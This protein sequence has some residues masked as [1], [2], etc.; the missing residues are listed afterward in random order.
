MS[1]NRSSSTPQRRQRDPLKTH[2]RQTVLERTQRQRAE[3]VRRERQW[4][5]Q[6]KRGLLDPDGAEWLGAAHPGATVA[7]GA[8]QLAAV[9]AAGQWLAVHLPTLR[10][11]ELVAA[12]PRPGW[13][14]LEAIL[15]GSGPLAWQ[16]ALEQTD[17]WSVLLAT[18]VRTTA[19]L[20][21]SGRA[22]ESADLVLWRLVASG[23]S[24]EVPSAADGGAG[25]RRHCVSLLLLST[26]SL[27]PHLVRRL[28]RPPTEHTTAVDWQEV[29]ELALVV[30]YALADVH[31]W[32]VD[33]VTGQRHT[34]AG[35]SADPLLRWTA[36]LTAALLAWLWVA[37]GG[38][39]SSVAVSEGVP[40]GAASRL[41]V[42]LAQLATEVGESERP[43]MAALPLLNVVVPLWPRWPEEVGWV[44]AR[45]TD[46]AHPE[47][48]QQVTAAGCAPYVVAALAPDAP[49]GLVR[50][51]LQV[52]CNLSSGSV[53]AL[54]AVLRHTV[55]YSYLGR[56]LASEERDVVRDVLLLLGNTVMEGE[57]HRRLIETGVLQQALALVADYDSAAEAELTWVLFH[58]LRRGEYDLV[59]WVVAHGG[60]EA[61][62]HL[63]A[64]H[65]HRAELLQ[66]TLECVEACVYSGGPHALHFET[67]G[68][69]ELLA[70]VQRWHADGNAAC[71]ALA[72]QLLD[73]CYTEGDGGYELTDDD[74]DDDDDS[75]ADDDHDH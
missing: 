20:D 74:D 8:A 56:L 54:Q 45:L 3:R 71:Y 47:L 17:L 70:T 43:V 33:R 36:P 12:D 11:F 24:L 25:L 49:P 62:V 16:S 69:V 28:E 23:L 6:A 46:S 9:A 37:S 55:V 51:A 30:G 15:T 58:L 48:V 7:D 66:R 50:P 57:Y 29:L 31:V 53:V 67:L 59:D 68:G 26:D 18:L 61:L 39:E 65:E 32:P 21:A 13:L 44:V 40:S 34:A 19:E 1:S 27:V 60:L 5:T 64:A 52:L 63:L 75:A 35:A 42:A 2:D 10:A 14:A 41:L 4:R 73:E 72:T 38:G 22:I